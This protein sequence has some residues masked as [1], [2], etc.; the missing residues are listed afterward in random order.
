MSELTQWHNEV[1]GQR[2]A[3]ALNKNNFKAVYFAQRQDA[4]NY[5]MELIPDGAAIGVGGSRTALELGLIETLEQRGHEM[6][7]HNQAGLTP[8]E[9]IARRYQQLTCD[10]FLTGT[11]AITLAGE[12]VNRDAF[13]NRAAAMMFG[14]KKVIIVVGS[15]KIVR[16]LA[17]A[18]KR[19]KL[20]AAP[21]NNKKYEL[22]NPCV[23]TGECMEC[24]N[25]TRTCNITTVLSRRPPLTDIQVVILGEN[26][27]F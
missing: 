18:D 24:K 7:N 16:D 20:Y 19:I 12:I 13:G 5:I 26:L 23:R 9:R 4:V 14:P 2:A 6:F 10:V 15:N 8:E 3:E 1:I 11:N 22:P 21:L 17:E 27:G 25:S